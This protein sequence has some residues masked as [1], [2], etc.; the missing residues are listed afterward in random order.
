[1]Q[2][3]IIKYTILLFLIISTSCTD[4]LTDDEQYKSVHLKDGAWIQYSN[5]DIQEYLTDDFTIEIWVSGD[6]N[7]SN[8]AKTL[9]SIIEDTNDDIINDLKELP[10]SQNIN[11]YIEDFDLKQQFN[12][13]KQNAY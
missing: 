10:L 11:E 1:M 9:L 12:D 8:D 5:I 7:E 6:S 3:L 2:N 4:L 13:F